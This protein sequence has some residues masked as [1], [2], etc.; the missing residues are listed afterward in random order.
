MA[1]PDGTVEL[2]S[3]EAYNRVKLGTTEL[4]EQIKHIKE[5]NR[6]LSG[7]RTPASSDSAVSQ[8]TAQLQAQEATIRRLQ[9]DY[10]RLAEVR[11]TATQRTAE[12]VVNQRILNQNAIQAATINSQLAGAYRRL[13]AEVAQAAQ[14]YQDLIAR[15]RLAGQSQR[16]FNRELRAASAEFNTLQ[17]RVL[18]ADRAVGRWQRTG[19][20]SITVARDLVNAFG[21][22]TGVTLFAALARDV[23][24]TTRELQ[25]MDL[26]LRQVLGS[27]KEAASAQQFLSTISENYG[28]NIQVLT[29]SYIG[30][31]AA[32]KT[33]IDT[34]KISGQQIRD[35]FQ[36]VSKA[37]GAMGLSVDQQQGAFLALSQMM[38]KGKVSAEE[39]NQQ[40]SERLPGA[41][42]ILAKSMGVTEIQLNKMLK[43]G[44][45][46][47]AEVLPAFAKELE[48]AYGV[49]NL[50]RVESLAAAT[51]RFSNAWT[52]MIRTMNEGDSVFSNTLTFLIDSLSKV[53]EGFSFLL[54]SQKQL[55]QD[56]ENS[57]FTKAYEEELDFLNRLE[58][59]WVR[60]AQARTRFN[61]LNAALEGGNG[62]REQR[63]KLQAELKFLRAEYAKMSAL[64]K[65]TG[66][67]KP[68][69]TD[70]ASTEAEINK[71]N[72]IIS[73][74]EGTLSALGETLDSTTKKEENLTKARAGRSYDP[75]AAIL[76]ARLRYLK[77][78]M[79]AN[80][81]EYE[82]SKANT[83]RQIRNLNEIATNEKLSYEARINAYGQM[84]RKKEEMLAADLTR[85]NMRLEEQRKLELDEALK[86]YN[87]NLKKA[88]P[89]DAS[90][91]TAEQQRAVNEITRL[92]GL[93]RIEINR[94]IDE[95]IKEADI[96]NSKELQEVAK[97]NSEALI[98]IENKRRELILSTDK[99]Y[100][101]QQIALFKKTADNESLSLEIRQANFRTYIALKQKQIDID[102]AAAIAASNQSKEELDA[103]QARFAVVQDLL[104]QENQ[105]ES[106]FAKSVD[107]ANAALKSLRDTLTSGIFENAGFS[108]LEKLFDGSF[109]KII[110][111]FDNMATEVA[112]RGGTLEEILA[113]QNEASL[114]K[115]QYTF[116]TIAEVAKQAYG[117]INQFQ[118][119]NFDAEYMRLEKQKN[120]ALM[121]A[122]ESATARAEIER[123]YEEKRRQ[124]AQR[125]ARAKKET[126][127]FSA[128]VDTASAVV[129]ALPNYILAA[130]VAVL[131]AAQ[132]AIISSQQIPEFYKGTENA[133]GGLAWVDERGPEIHTDKHGRIKSTG[134]EKGANLRWLE[135]GD[136]IKTAAESRLMFDRGL[137]DI[138]Q[139]NGILPPVVVNNSGIT[140]AQIDRLAVIL[141]KPQGSTNEVSFSERG[142]E[143]YKL[144]QGKRI[145]ILNSSLRLKSRNV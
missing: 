35:I 106:P 5:I 78:L 124:I 50:H 43:D 95:S 31:F 26:A 127:L 6:L 79:E 23:F 7:S 24:N 121:F 42:G 21:I 34:G 12:E 48:R 62:L 67:S 80:D 89:A 73:T 18:A 13:S 137:N 56:A 51:T 118:Q 55:Q 17:T 8:L 97:Q 38:S 141:D 142:I 93:E 70:I 14:K 59:G 87:A 47:A 103:I 15:G 123:Q 63:Q 110:A 57:L 29:K 19:E 82:A 27:E 126:A 60:T 138:M 108:G 104:N 74:Y 122:G 52:E 11:R 85:T 20:R 37:A 54:T 9:Q 131:G 44:K 114:K 66:V 53:M 28:I 96:T 129:A 40:L 64:S 33:A 65:L 77:E 92:Y 113:A 90:K 133:P 4:V 1:A 32:S 98:V 132:I 109:D 22:A 134:S 117:F 41:F 105:N 46:L 72:E 88:A 144:Q 120:V 75:Q 81:A 3:E 101:D 135:K 84:L 116:A 99:T 119:E 136:K 143:F 30:F 83:E 36:S 2:L 94:H 139:N 111:G 68:L 115:F 145:Q 45:V 86:A 49:D 125:E 39:L 102:K 140:D 112:K 10:T 76:A 107:E 25:S 16:D 61:D 128:I 130:A 91:R 58:E 69:E 100:R 71:L